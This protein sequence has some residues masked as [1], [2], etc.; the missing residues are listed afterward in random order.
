MKKLLLII[1]LTFSL[2]I[3][4]KTK[5][6]TLIIETEPNVKIF[7]DGIFQLET[8][9]SQNRI[10]LTDVQKGRYTIL[11]VKD[12]CLAQKKKIRIKK[13]KESLWKTEP[14]KKAPLIDPFAVYDT[15]PRLIKKAPIIYPEHL[16][17]L[18]VTGKVLVRVEVWADGSVGEV[19]VLQTP[20]KDL[21]KPVI[22][23]VKKYKYTPAY[24]DGIPVG[25]MVI[26]AV[27]IEK[28]KDIHSQPR[29]GDIRNVRVHP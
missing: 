3:C 28:R 24:Y 2:L 6:G 17:K 26:F 20:H 1:F 25:V 8:T 9:N 29:T 22:D 27:R 11:A 16:L 19:T 4:A 5:T 15:P 13:N 7:I 10:V 12:S 23:A 18:K 14:F 21:N